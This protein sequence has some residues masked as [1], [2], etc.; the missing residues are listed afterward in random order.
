MLQTKVKS[1]SSSYSSSAGV[2]RF[3]A[4]Q[5]PEFP[6]M[7]VSGLPVSPLAIRRDPR[8]GKGQRSTFEDTYGSPPP[9]ESGRRERS[10]IT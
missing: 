8:V 4:G 3:A 2:P 5:R 6:R 1:E 9:S 10:K 7:K